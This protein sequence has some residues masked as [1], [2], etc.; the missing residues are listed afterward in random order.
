VNGVARRS[1]HEQRAPA[2]VRA[3]RDREAQQDLAFD[4]ARRVEGLRRDERP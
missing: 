3:H 4:F 2:L 1:D